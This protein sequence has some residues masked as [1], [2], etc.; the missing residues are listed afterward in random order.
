MI[1]GG[2]QDGRRCR[3]LLWDEG[4]RL[5][6]MGVSSDRGHSA[7]LQQCGDSTGQA[8]LGPQLCKD[9]PGSLEEDALPNTRAALENSSMSAV[10]RRGGVGGWVG[11]GGRR[12]WV[13]TSGAG[14]TSRA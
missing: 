7:G 6:S 14:G 5:G 3:R 9:S 1:R 4:P 12:V 13:C 11:G 2:E 10:E 8:A